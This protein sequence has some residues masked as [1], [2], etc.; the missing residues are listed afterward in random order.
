MSSS[1][2]TAAT[3]QRLTFFRFP[4]PSSAGCIL[5]PVGSNRGVSACGSAGG[6]GGTDTSQQFQGNLPGS[7]VIHVIDE[8]GS[9]PQWSCCQ[10]KYTRKFLRANKGNTLRAYV[11]PPPQDVDFKGYPKGFVEESKC[12]Q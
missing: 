7:Y 2:S 8:N 10:L 6:C 9:R 4:D 5:N 12:V 3:S 1:G 11:P